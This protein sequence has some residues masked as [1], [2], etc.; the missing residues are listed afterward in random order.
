MDASISN[1]AHFPAES[2]RELLDASPI[3]TVLLDEQAKCILF[4]NDAFTRFLGVESQTAAG[5]PVETFLAFDLL[6]S[7]AVQQRPGRG[8]EPWRITATST[9]GGDVIRLSCMLWRVKLGGKDTVQMECVAEEE[10]ERHDLATYQKWIHAVGHELKSPLTSVKGYVEIL[11]SELVSSGNPQVRT[12]LEIVRRNSERMHSYIEDMYRFSLAEINTLQCETTTVRAM[13]DQV[14][15]EL[16]GDIARHDITLDVDVSDRPVRLPGS[17]V[18]EA[19]YQVLHSS[20]TV[21]EPKSTVIIVREHDMGARVV[22]V[23]QHEPR[24]TVPR[25]SAHV[26][27]IVDGVRN[28]G[29][30]TTLGFEFARKILIE[31]GGDAFLEAGDNHFHTCYLLLPT[32]VND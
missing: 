16:S 20:L 7:L 27:A 21:S 28:S 11:A 5:L 15:H 9:S 6:P 25:A 1:E 14:L 13:L 30:A 10:N 32:C 19:L 2:C 4:C 22:L 29:N 24:Q 17:A 12:I 3:P 8:G 26:K 18:R 31:A 23:L